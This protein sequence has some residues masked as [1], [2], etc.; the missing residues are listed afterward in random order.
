MLRIAPAADDQSGRV[1]VM[2]ETA[3]GRTARVAFNVTVEN[4]VKIDSVVRKGNRLDI[5]GRGFGAT[6]AIVTINGQPVS[7]FITRQADNSIVLKGTKK[8]LKLTRGANQITVT[9]GGTISNTFV[10]NLPNK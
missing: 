3:D 2:V 8:Q 5:S 6:G 4:T 9:A 7:L 10:V 1:V